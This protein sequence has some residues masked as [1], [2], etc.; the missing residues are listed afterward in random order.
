[1][2]SASI[3]R[4]I[5]GIIALMMEAARASEISSNFYQTTWCNNPETAV[6]R[7]FI[8]CILHQVLLG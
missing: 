5:R 7:N 3:I 6:F 4:T 8:I 2:L 1:V